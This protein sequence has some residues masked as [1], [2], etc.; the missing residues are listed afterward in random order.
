MQIFIASLTGQTTML[1]VQEDDTVR[2]VKMQFKDKQ[3]TP[4]DQQRLLYGGEELDD[5][6]TLKDYGIER[7]STLHLVLRLPGGLNPA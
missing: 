5:K 1:L 4:V 7:D 6:K 3:G 2:S